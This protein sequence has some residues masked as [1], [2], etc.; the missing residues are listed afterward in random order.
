MYDQQDNEIGNEILNNEEEKKYKSPLGDFAFFQEQLLIFGSSWKIAVLLG[1]YIFSIV[2]S[3]WALILIISVIDLIPATINLSVFFIAYGIGFLIS[4][5]IP[6]AVIIMFFAAKKLNPTL[7]AKGT[8]ILV[9][10][11]KVSRFLLIVSA[12]IMAIALFILLF[13]NPLFA[14]VAGLIMGLLYFVMLKYYKV[15]IEFLEKIYL[16]I[17]G[18]RDS[19]PNPESVI[20]FMLVFLLLSVISILFTIGDAAMN[21][22]GDMFG[23]ATADYQEMLNLLTDNDSSF[24]SSLLSLGS[25]VYM[26]YVMYSYKKHCFLKTPPTL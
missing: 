1:F 5:I 20:N 22:G 8:S 16:C 18:K 12:V 23:G 14:I 25:L 19:M 9:V 21:T 4:L 6:T 10:Y 26:L 13:L 17:S 15:L 24:I 7:A 2:T 11:Y 3:I